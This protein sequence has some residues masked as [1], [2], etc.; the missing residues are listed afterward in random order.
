MLKEN[1][2]RGVVT[3]HIIWE[4]ALMTTDLK[5]KCKAFEISDNVTSMVFGSI[6]ILKEIQE[7]YPDRG[8]IDSSSTDG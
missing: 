5:S 1:I 7:H 2:D 8:C 4:E 3:Q 6:S